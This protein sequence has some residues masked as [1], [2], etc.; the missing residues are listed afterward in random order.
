MADLVREGKVRYL[1]LSECSANTLRR[2]YAIHPIAAVQ[3]EYSPWTL[4]IETNGLLDACKELGVAIVAYSPLGRG[5]LTGKLKTPEDFGDDDF[6][7]WTPRY[8]GENFYKN[9]DVVRKLEEIAQ[10]KGCDVGQL[11]LAWVLKQG[12]YFFA[13]PGTTKVENLERNMGAVAVEL[14]DEENREIRGVIREIGVA[15]ER[16]P[17]AYMERVNI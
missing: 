17:K 9:L 11:T 16:L 14:T 1:G 3:V 13:I 7:K 5:F 15:G 12:E 8:Q 10:R 4:D 6:R 2:A